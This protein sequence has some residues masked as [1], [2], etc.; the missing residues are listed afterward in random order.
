MITLDEILNTTCDVIGLEKGD[1]TSKRKIDETH[2]AAR[3]IYCRVAANLHPQMGH[4][5]IGRKINRARENVWHNIKNSKSASA[6]EYEY[7]EKKI[8]EKLN[9]E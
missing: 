8:I 9:G 6:F 5:A 7:Y 1:I 3:V 2:Q 4:R